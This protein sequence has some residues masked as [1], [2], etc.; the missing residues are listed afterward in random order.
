[1]RTHSFMLTTPHLK[2]AF[3][4]RLTILAWLAFTGLC[5]GQLGGH[6]WLLELFAHFV[7][8]Y[9]VFMAL[10]GLCA[11]SKKQRIFFTICTLVSVFWCATPWPLNRSAENISNIS[12]QAQPVYL[13]SY[14]V[15]FSN[16]QVNTESIW[17][18][19][20]QSDV[21]F[22]TEASPSWARALQPLEDMTDHCAQY[23]DS[24]FGIA[25]YSRLPLTSCEVLYTSHNTSYP[26]IRAVLKNGV[27]VYGIHPP[28]PI[29]S[30][31]AQE[32]NAML[33][34]LAIQIAQEQHNVVVLGDMNITPFSPVFQNFIQTANIHLTSPRIRPTWW[35]GMLSIDH[36]LV[37]KPENVVK[38]G[39]YGWQ[40]SDH[41]PIWISYL[42]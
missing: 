8:Y 27:V 14:N 11:I 28:P 7:P 22:L 30:T 6:H 42:P 16:P 18:A 19:Q 37:R 20:L 23:A 35:P 10:G 5:L 33:Q 17:L 40:G 9:A 15:L 31:L 24:P 13:L 21:I 25:L 39:R 3:Q 29:D 38:T 2:S 32:R 26:Y 1:M 36:V 4:K 34:A 12:E 41:Q